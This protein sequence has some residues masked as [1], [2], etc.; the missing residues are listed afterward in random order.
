MTMIKAAA[1][2]RQPS[3]VLGVSTLIGTLTAVLTTQITW[4]NAVPAVAGALAAIALPDNPRAQVAIKDG[5]EAVVTAEQ[6]VTNSFK[7][8]A[9][10]GIAK[11]ASMVALLL[12]G[13]LA[14]SACAVQPTP[15]VHAAV[16][17]QNTYA[18]VLGDDVRVQAVGA[19][20]A[21]VAAYRAAKVA[22]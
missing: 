4:Q 6:T 9:I 15:Q 14:L 18:S 5:T 20:V 13:G 19:A 12:A 16:R 1:F 22:R 8:T 17:S 10:V 11:T 3:T 2:M 21:A 7:E